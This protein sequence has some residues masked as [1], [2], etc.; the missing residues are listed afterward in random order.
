MTFLNSPP[1]YFFMALFFEQNL[2]VLY[3]PKSQQIFYDLLKDI[4]LPILK[5]QVVPKNSNQPSSQGK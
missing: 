5:D 4:S 2:W 1:E 3:P